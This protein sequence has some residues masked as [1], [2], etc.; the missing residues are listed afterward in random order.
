MLSNFILNYEL[1]TIIDDKINDNKLNKVPELPIIPAFFT[2]L[3][4]GSTI[5]ISPG[6]QLKP[7]KSEW[8]GKI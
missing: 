7:L 3:V 5:I 2:L 1:I 6:N 4:F 8:E